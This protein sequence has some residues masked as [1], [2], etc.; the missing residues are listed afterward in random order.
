MVLES[1]RRYEVFFAICH[2]V[3]EL[4]GFQFHCPMGL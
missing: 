2:V 4:I 3:V 1:D